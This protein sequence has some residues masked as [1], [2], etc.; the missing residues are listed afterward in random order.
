MCRQRGFIHRGRYSNQSD[1]PKCQ[2][3][4]LLE[5]QTKEAN[6]I[7]QDNSETEQAGKQDRIMNLADKLRTKQRMAWRSAPV[8]A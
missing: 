2:A 5:N 7:H 3:K 1:S 6:L 4:L 8:T